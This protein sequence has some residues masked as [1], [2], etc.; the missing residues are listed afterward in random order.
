MCGQGETS[1]QGVANLMTAD[2]LCIEHADGWVPF[3]LSARILRVYIRGRARTCIDNVG[4]PS[5]QHV[6]EQ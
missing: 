3:I 1:P 2:W 4:I 6:G 5:L